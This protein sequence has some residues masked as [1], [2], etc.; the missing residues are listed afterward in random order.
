MKT[1]SNLTDFDASRNSPIKYTRLKAPKVLVLVFGMPRP[2]KKGIACHGGMQTHR[3]SRLSF[4]ALNND[5]K[6]VE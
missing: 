3:F 6:K 1:P 2:F 4:V 5:K